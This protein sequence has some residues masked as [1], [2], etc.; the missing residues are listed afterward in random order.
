MHFYT[1]NEIEYLKEITPGRTN[2][3]IT[4]MFN[5]RFNLDLSKKAISGTRKRFGFL[6]GSDGRFEKGRIPVNKGLKKYWEGGEETQFKKGHK[7]HNWVPIGSERISKDGYIQIKIQEGKFQHNWRG[8]HI[9]VWEAHNGP[10]PK[11]HS[12]VFGD[13][14]NRNF[15]ISNLILVTRAQLLYLNRHSLIKNNVEITKIGVAL[16]KIDKKLNERKRG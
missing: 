10:L 4:K 2:A 11:G 13:G 8:K 16:A 15:D 12:I 1:T 3:E 5:K 6:T 14:D 7:P 9:L